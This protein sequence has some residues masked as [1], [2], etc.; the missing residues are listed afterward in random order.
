MPAKLCT[1]ALLFLVGR[2]VQLP[3]EVC[4]FAVTAACVGDERGEG[5]SN[6]KWGNSPIS[7]LMSL[8]E[9]KEGDGWKDAHQGCRCSDFCSSSFRA[10]KDVLAA[11]SIFPLQAVLVCLS[12]VPCNHNL[13]S[14]E[15][16]AGE[17][18]EE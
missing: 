12:R 15:Y 4:F 8:V 13:A 10:R 3:G 9:K 6:K 18:R 17:R 14:E 5:E 1:L 16:R 2:R 7:K 11:Q